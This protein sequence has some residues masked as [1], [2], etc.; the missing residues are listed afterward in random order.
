M[1][2][3]LNKLEKVVELA[4]G[5]KRAR[6][7]ACAEG[8]SDHKGEHLRIYP[9]GK[10]GCCVFP[11]D[12]EHRKRIFA[13]A[14]QRSRQAIRVRVAATATAPVRS[15]IMGKI[16]QVFGSS[17]VT[18]STIG[19]PDAPDGVNEVGQQFIEPDGTDGVGE[20]EP[21]LETGS[22]VQMVSDGDLFTDSRTLRTPQLSL[23][24]AQEGSEVE[25]DNST[26]A[27]LKEF[28]K[29]VRGVR[30]G[31]EG[32][33][34]PPCGEPPVRLPFFTADGTLSIP[35]DSPGRY[36]WWRGGQSV[37]ETIAELRAREQEV[38]NAALF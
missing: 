2:L 15:G 6:C 27:T 26:C 19:A 36:H 32:S 4:D 30:L 21:Q 28:C 34:A 9:D 18:Y 3:D 13:L 37:K 31:C 14:G 38:A 23:Y 22:P 17:G 5:M 25:K 24:V 33:D 20:V 35:F 29:G 12:R 10:F 1:S 8:G 11:Q 16:G 7:P